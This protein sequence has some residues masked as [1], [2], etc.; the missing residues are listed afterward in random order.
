MQSG[1]SAVPRKT[2]DTVTVPKCQESGKAAGT[3][4]AAEE[5]RESAEEMAGNGYLLMLGK[6]LAPIPAR[7]WPAA[8]TPVPS[9]GPPE[10]TRPGRGRPRPAT[11][12]PGPPLPSLSRQPWRGGAAAYLFRYLCQGT[13]SKATLE[14]SASTSFSSRGTPSLASSVP[15]GA[16]EFPMTTCNI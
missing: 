4:P 15:P 13:P 7:R 10:S 6:P 8:L 3:I 16:R 9:P 5:C 2:R 1:P 11:S 12:P 14:L